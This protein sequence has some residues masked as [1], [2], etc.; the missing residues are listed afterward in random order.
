MS[1][2]K[3]IWLAFLGQ[4]AKGRSGADGIRAEGTEAAGVSLGQAPRAPPGQGLP[5]CWG[6]VPWQGWAGAGA[7][8]GPGSEGGDLSQG[9]V[10]AVVAELWHPGDGEQPCATLL[11][12]LW[13]AQG[14]EVLQDSR[15]LSCSCPLA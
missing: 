15:G 2:G 13:C 4:A 9:D 10:A 12:A 8:Q 5:S 7:T 1:E 11:L 6:K 3:D 14:A